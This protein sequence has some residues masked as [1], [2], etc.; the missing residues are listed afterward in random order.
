MKDS[1]EKGLAST[2]TYT[3]TAEMTPPSVPAPV[4]A[5]PRM[6]AL[7]EHACVESLKPHLDDG[8][9]TLGTHVNVSHEG[10]ARV[11]QEIVVHTRLIEIERR[12]L[13]FEIEVVAP[14]GVISTG[15]HQRTVVPISVFSRRGLRPRRRA[16]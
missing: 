13:Q 14:C 8:E 6:I 4:L 5:T 2:R 1:L 12:R 10:A 7:I 11:G 9:I 3:V 15:T 16:S